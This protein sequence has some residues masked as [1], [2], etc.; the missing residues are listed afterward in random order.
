MIYLLVRYEHFLCSIF[1]Y[2]NNNNHKIINKLLVL[3]N[4]YVLHFKKKYLNKCAN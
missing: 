4:F 1:Y 3:S 2:L